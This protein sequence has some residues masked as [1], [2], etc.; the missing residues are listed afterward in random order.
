MTAE[1][2]FKPLEPVRQPSGKT[3]YAWAVRGD[4]DPAAVHSNT[5]SIELPK[6]SGKMR[7]FPEIDRAEWFSIN[8]ARQKLLK[9][10]VPFLDQLAKMP[11]ADG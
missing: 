9:G 1:G 5:F 6:G 2:E 8:E 4:I 10:Q 7:E 11:L 3:I